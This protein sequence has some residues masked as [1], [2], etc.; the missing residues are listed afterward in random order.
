M[1]DHP[2]LYDSEGH[3]LPELEQRVKEAIQ[4]YPV[5]EAEWWL[6]PVA[7]IRVVS[8]WLLEGTDK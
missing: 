3:V 2:M 4:R 7:A 6:G 5:M 1:S 8:D